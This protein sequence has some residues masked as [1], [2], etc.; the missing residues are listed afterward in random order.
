VPWF[1]QR[2]RAIDR[3]RAIACARVLFDSATS[4]DDTAQSHDCSAPRR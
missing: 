1:A 3:D 2:D 4:T